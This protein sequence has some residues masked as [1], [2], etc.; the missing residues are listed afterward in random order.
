MGKLEKLIYID[1]S[2]HPN[3]G[4]IVYG[5]IEFSP[6]RWSDVLGAW[7]SHRK[8][9]YRNYEVPVTK[10]LHMTEYVLGRGRI[11]INAPRKF[12][13]ED[14]STLWKDLGGEVAQAGLECMRCTE[15]LTVGAV[16]RKGTKESWNSDK[17]ALY[18]GLIEI[19]EQSLSQTESYGMIFMDGD[20]SDKTYQKVHR[21]LSRKKR[22]IIEDPIHLDSKNS[23]LMQ[24]ADHVAWCA[25]SSIMKVS[26]HAFAH[27]WYATYLAERDP[28]RAPR[29]LE[30]S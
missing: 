4:L 29:T 7:L 9:L 3:A 19:F 25:N 6:D 5:W 13:K 22:R 2:G 24:M 28:F 30:N 23:Q 8:S 15:G 11:S 21:E 20:G 17:E 10:E 16:Y 12:L 1:D 26:K 27:N 18:S 14:G